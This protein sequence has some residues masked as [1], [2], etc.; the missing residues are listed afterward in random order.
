MSISNESN[1]TAAQ[2]F[3]TLAEILLKGTEWDR[4]A[5]Q[6]TMAKPGEV[7]KTDTD[8]RLKKAMP[9]YMVFLT[10]QLSSD[11]VLRFVEDSYGQG[12]RMLQR[13]AW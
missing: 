11:G 5:I 12:G 7:M 1:A 3:L 4:T 6:A 13:G 9:V 10:S 2:N 8:A